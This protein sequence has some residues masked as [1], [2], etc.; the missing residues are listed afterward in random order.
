M[1]LSDIDTAI[2]YLTVATELSKIEHEKFNPT[3]LLFHIKRTQNF[4]EFYFFLSKI[5]KV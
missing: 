5:C 3:E 1:K 4:L 2:D